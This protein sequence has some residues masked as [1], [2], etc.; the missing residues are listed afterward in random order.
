VEVFRV[1]RT[2]S[3]GAH[4]D[5]VKLHS[6]TV[7]GRESVQHQLRGLWKDVCQRAEQGEAPDRQV[8]VLRG[9]SGIGKSRLAADLCDHVSAEGKVAFRIGCSPF[10]TNVALWPMARFL[11]LRW[12]LVPEQ[13]PDEQIDIV[14]HR[15]AGIA[16]DSPTA[17]PLIASML[18][19]ASTGEPAGADLN[20]L[21]R[22]AEMLRV[23]VQWL[24]LAAR[25]HPCLMVVDDLQWSD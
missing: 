10:H 17:V 25:Q 16:F 11:E 21:A 13:T 8:A 12:G 1:A 15:T 19:L 22:R 5:T 2:R 6:S 18:G 3:A 7:V 4:L 9:P 23:L 14:K 20:P 24:T